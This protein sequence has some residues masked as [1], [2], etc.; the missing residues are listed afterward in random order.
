VRAVVAAVAVL[1]LGALVA[2]NQLGRWISAGL[3]LPLPGNVVGMLLLYGLLALRVVR[4]EWLE[5]TAGLFNRHLAFF[6]IPL[7]VGL[8]A[9]P[10]SLVRGHGIALVVI[11]VT[12]AV[13][14]VAATGGLAAWLDRRSG[15]ERP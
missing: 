6:F 5:P 8:L 4:L 2:L 1:Q 14:G 13:L 7:V 12:T 10:G 9:L 15:G 3:H 11:L